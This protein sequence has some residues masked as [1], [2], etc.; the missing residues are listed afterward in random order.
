MQIRS[1]L[2]QRRVAGKS[3]LEH[4]QLILD[5]LKRNKILEFAASVLRSLQA[6]MDH[7]IKKEE[8]ACGTE[9]F[10]IR[11]LLNMLSI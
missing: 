9:N 10:P 4:K 5:H 11:L 3:K 6:E 2:M 1:I 7:T 8:A